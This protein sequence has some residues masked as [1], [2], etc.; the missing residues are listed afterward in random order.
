MPVF[1]TDLK[2]P[3]LPTGTRGRESPV[4]S[5]AWQPHGVR[6]PPDWHTLPW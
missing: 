1:D 6:Y 5:R 4:H 3:A 2:I